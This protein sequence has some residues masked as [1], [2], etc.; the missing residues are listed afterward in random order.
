MAEE[1]HQQD[2]L[3]EAAEDVVVPLPDRTADDREPIEGCEHHV[4]DPVDPPWHH[5][6]EVDHHGRDD[7]VQGGEE[8][9]RL[10][11]V[12]DEHLSCV[13]VR[14]NVGTIQRKQVDIGEDQHR[15]CPQRSD[16]QPGVDRSVGVSVAGHEPVTACRWSARRCGADE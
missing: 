9:E 2:G 7:D 3:D 6:R 5:Q 16:L 4:D 14:P 10:A 12:K 8:E 15:G 1:H 11:D 13:E